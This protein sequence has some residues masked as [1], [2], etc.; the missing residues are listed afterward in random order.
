MSYSE[1]DF[2][3][4]YEEYYRRYEEEEGP[5]VYG[6]L[7]GNHNDYF[8]DL[9]YQEAMRLLPMIEEDLE[10]YEEEGYADTSCS[11]SGRG[12]RNDADYF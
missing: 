11:T 1:Q 3:E 9:S 7:M 6:C 8:Y 12:S 5:Y 2:D 10:Q 4:Q